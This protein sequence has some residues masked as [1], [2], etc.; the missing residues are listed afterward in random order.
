MIQENVER[1]GNMAFI[2]FAL[3]LF[4]LK[5]KLERTFGTIVRA[6]VYPCSVPAMVLSRVNTSL[7]M[8]ILLYTFSKITL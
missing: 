8:F 3:L 4:D 7:N 2:L 5:D 1:H 6:Q